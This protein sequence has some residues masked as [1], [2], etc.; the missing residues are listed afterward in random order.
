MTGEMS[1]FI[2][3]KKLLESVGFEV[4]MD[5]SIGSLDYVA[6]VRIEHD[7]VK[8]ADMST[9]EGRRVYHMN[10]KA[11]GINES[12]VNEERLGGSTVGMNHRNSELVNKSWTWIDVKAIQEEL[13]K[14]GITVTEQHGQAE[15]TRTW[16]DEPT[17]GTPGVEGPYGENSASIFY[18]TTKSKR[19]W[20]I[21][22]AGG[23]DAWNKFEAF[24]EPSVDRGDYDEQRSLIENHLELLIKKNIPSYSGKDSDDY[25]V[26]VTFKG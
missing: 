6:T 8:V 10:A 25:K 22:F 15:V 7:T 1:K 18:F 16:D 19:T 23:S 5:E 12:R 26:N 21:K 17:T 3:A 11:F 4:R 14:Y 9:R 2:K 13:A 24:F 20:M